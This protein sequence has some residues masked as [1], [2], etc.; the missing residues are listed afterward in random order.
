MAGVIFGSIGIG[1]VPNRAPCALAVGALLLVEGAKIIG[2]GNA[3]E[4]ISRLTWLSLVC[5]GLHTPGTRA[6]GASTTCAAALSGAGR[7]F[8]H[9]GAGATHVLGTCGTTVAAG[10]QGLIFRWHVLW[11]FLAM[12]ALH[13]NKVGLVPCTAPFAIAALAVCLILRAVWVA[14]NSCCIG[15]ST[16]LQGI[17]S[18]NG[19]L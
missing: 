6:P 11:H 2:F 16:L 4:G 1:D 17:N 19:T 12:S 3:I 14:G 9:V 10:A 7:V 18:C 8:S 13:K 15:C 5:K